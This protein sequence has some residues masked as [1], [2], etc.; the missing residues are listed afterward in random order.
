MSVTAT[1]VCSKPELQAF[2]FLGA[3]YGEDCEGMF[4]SGPLPAEKNR[5][6]EPHGQAYRRKP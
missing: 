3:D 2:L 4:R 1:F 5:E 6:N